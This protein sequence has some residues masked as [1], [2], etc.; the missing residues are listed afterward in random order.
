LQLHR[1]DPKV[2]LAE[3]IGEL[4]ALKDEGKIR[5]IGVSNVTEQQYNE[6]A[7]LTPIVSIQN[8][9][10]VSDRRSDSVL[11]LCQ[12]RRIAFLPWAPIQNLDSHPGVQEVAS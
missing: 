6:A 7:E 3:S 4:V 5:H 11:D 2:P 10:N 9:F 1:P 12:Q 8:R